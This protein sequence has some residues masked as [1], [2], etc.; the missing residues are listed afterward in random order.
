L[1][2]EGYLVSTLESKAHKTT[3]GNTSKPN[4]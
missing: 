4:S 2:H 3:S 1:I